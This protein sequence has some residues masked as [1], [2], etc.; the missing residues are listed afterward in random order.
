TISTGYL[1]LAKSNATKKLDWQGITG[2]MAMGYF[3]GDTTWLEGIRIFE[4]A[5]FYHFDKDLALVTKKRY[6]TWTYEPT[7][8]PPEG[9]ME[10]LRAIV[11]SSLSVAVNNK[12]AAIPISGGLDS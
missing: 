9:Q 11:Q 6:W 10:N 8:Q 2:F 1:A 5:S 3:P 7:H 4:P 12:R